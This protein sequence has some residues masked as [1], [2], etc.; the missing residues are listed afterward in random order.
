MVG[1]DNVG[2]DVELDRN[3][4][5]GEAGEDV[6][7]EMARLGG[8]FRQTAREGD[9]GGTVAVEFTFFLAAAIEPML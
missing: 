8:V 2:D 5:V 6:K 7:T 9:G 1:T 3:E 4:P